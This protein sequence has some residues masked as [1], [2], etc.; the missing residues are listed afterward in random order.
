MMKAALRLEI[1]SAE[2]ALFSDT[3][4]M[5]FVTGEMGELGITP[6]HT[7]LVTT[8]RPGNIRAVFPDGKEETFY[9]SGGMLEV[10]PFVVTVL[11]D[12]A[13]RA[14]SLDEA[15]AQAARERAEK[16]LQERNSEVDLAKAT[17]ELAEAIAQL[18][19]IQ[20]LREKIK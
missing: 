12:T 20:K 19:T 17:L 3:V 2:K 18:R 11:A 14:E 1:V 15:Q 6:G 10:Q 13:I 7:P 9:L 5:L 4:A 8:L 16:V